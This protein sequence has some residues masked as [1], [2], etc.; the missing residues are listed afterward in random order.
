MSK[1]LTL[2][3]EIGCLEKSELV[4]EHEIKILNS[5]LKVD[6]SGEH[7][8]E[9]ESRL[10]Q[11]SQELEKIKNEI[12]AGK[13]RIRNNEKKL[14]KFV[15]YEN[16][17]TSQE[18]EVFCVILIRKKIEKLIRILH[19]ENQKTKLLENILETNRKSYIKK[20]E[21]INELTERINENISPRIKFSMNRL[22]TASDN[23]PQSILNLSLEKKTAVGILRA[24]NAKLKKVYNEETRQNAKEV[25]NLLKQITDAKKAIR[26]IALEANK[27]CK[28]ID[29]ETPIMQIDYSTL[30]M[31]S[32]DSIPTATTIELRMQSGAHSAANKMLKSRIRANSRIKE[33][34][35]KIKWKSF[36][37][38]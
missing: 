23:R 2:V 31:K 37:F 16:S 38:H 24:E 17:I 22:S 25:S 26:K 33:R 6:T 36:I 4:L 19:S 3:S 9:L 11:K 21:K 14:A 32:R 30:G 10:V 35:E 7:I 13:I 12:F 15:S 20:Q 28:D 1:E 8:L 5:Q 18:I 27:K 29:S 34:T